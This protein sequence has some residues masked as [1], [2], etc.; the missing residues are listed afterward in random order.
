[1]YEYM[2]SIYCTRNVQFSLTTT[3]CI[4][5]TREKILH[6]RGIYYCRYYCY[7]WK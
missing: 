4:V 3:Y 7:L 1:M 5:K 6:V 2:Y